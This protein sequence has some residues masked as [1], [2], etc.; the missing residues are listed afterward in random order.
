[1]S[2]S[3]SLRLVPVNAADT[4]VITA[5]SQAGAETG[6]AWLQ[7]VGRTDVWRAAGTSATLTAALASPITAI[8]CIALMTSNLSAAAT[9]RV[10]LFSSASAVLFDSGVLLA[11]PPAPFGSFD[12]GFQG[13]GVN[14]FSFGLATQSVCWLPQRLPAASVVIDV[15]DPTNPAGYIQA[16]R[17]VIGDVW[18]P[19]NNF[20]WNSGLTWASSSKQQRTESG[21]LR[22][23]Q[24]A[25]FRKLSLSFEWMSEADRR[26]FSEIAQQVSTT[27]DFLLAAYPQAD[28]F[29]AAD[30]TM[31]AKFARDLATTARAFGVY[32]A[33]IEIEEA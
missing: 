18:S 27:R 26:R 5:S 12:W 7:T 13:L 25:Q 33:P 4:A 3:N 32:Q 15:A 1:M 29:K 19:D 8:D 16:S 28:Q 17:L 24:G 11:A 22:T 2:L 9:W 23:E 6:P 10:R 14:A 30:F 21:T 31:M 20:S